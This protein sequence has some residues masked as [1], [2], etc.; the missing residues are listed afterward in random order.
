LGAGLHPVLRRRQA[1]RGER[2]RIR[3]RRAETA[4]KPADVDDS[5]AEAPLFYLSYVAVVLVAAALVL[6]PGAPLIQI[7]FLS[8]ALNAVLLLVMLPFMR[9]LAADPEVMGAEAI[10]PTGR[11][12]TGL[13]LGLIAA[14]VLALAALS[15]VGSRP[16]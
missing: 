2:S 11:I 13:A 4:G 3:E 14:S 8:Q 1:S 5:F 15:I 10:G 16:G 6:V 9:R 12:I 7:V